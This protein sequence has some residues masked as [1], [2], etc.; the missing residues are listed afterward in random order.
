MFIEYAKGGVE[1]IL[2]KISVVNR[3]PEAASLRLLPTVWSRN[4]WSWGTKEQKPELHEFRSNARCVVELNHKELGRRWLHC[5]ENPDLLF[6]ENE[7]NSRRLFGV[8]NSSPYAK[9]GINDYCGPA[10]RCHDPADQASP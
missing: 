5:E 6:T 3:G 2:I 9:D 8:E 7:T 1:D 4:A 10:L